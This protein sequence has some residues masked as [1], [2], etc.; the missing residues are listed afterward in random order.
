MRKKQDAS[1][2]AMIAIDGPAASG[3]SSVGYLLA[4]QLG[5]LYFDTGVM[6]RAV[7]WA[8]LE[9]NLDLNDQEAVGRLAERLDIRIQPPLKDPMDHRRFTIL[10]GDQDVTWSIRTAEVDRNVSVVSANPKVRQALSRHQRRIGRRYARG[11]GD[12][13]GIVMVGRDIGTVV[14][15]EAPLKIFL[16]ASAGERACRR[17]AEL[18]ERGVE[19]SYE[20]ILADMERRDRLDRERTVAPLR[21]AE[22]AVVLDTTELPLEQVVAQILAL[23]GDGPSS[24]IG[25]MELT[26]E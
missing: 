25:R 6:Y 16:D 23:L 7:T 21:P 20:Q 11:D 3:K 8:A 24:T 19:A 18:A 5:Y 1:R 14:L 17:L 4:R 15:P 10:V 12:L 22:D 26:G 9:R 13:P 2:P